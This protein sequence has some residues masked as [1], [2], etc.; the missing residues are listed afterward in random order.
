MKIEPRSRGYITL[1]STLVVGAV[2]LSVVTATILLGLGSARNSFALQQSAAAK[3]LA[4][5]CVE[6]ALEE[7]RLDVAYTGTGGLTLS[8]GVCT[9][10]VSNTGGTSRM[11]Y[12]TGQAGEFIRKTKVTITDYD[13]VIV[14]SSWQDVTD[15]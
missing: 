10:A 7:I 15:F 6:E 9:H 8:T 3:S 11:I 12:G 2:G 13:P 1:I 5:A 14:I 4:N